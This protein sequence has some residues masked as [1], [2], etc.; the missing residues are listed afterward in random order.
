[1]FKLAV[2]PGDGIGQEVTEQALKVL[3][4]VKE[5]YGIEYE[6][7]SGLIGGSAIDARGPYPWRPGNWLRKVMR[8]S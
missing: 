7:A 5:K 4:A 3:A 6:T 2:L 1:M 8:F